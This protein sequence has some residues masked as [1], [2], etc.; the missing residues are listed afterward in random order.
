MCQSS[1]KGLM[2]D[3]QY[4]YKVRVQVSTAVRFVSYSNG[5]VSME[6]VL[7][8]KLPLPIF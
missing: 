6:F 4:E 3:V 1:S 7:D 8:Q 2:F 5:Q